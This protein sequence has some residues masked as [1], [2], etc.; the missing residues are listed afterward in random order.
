MALKISGSIFTVLLS[1]SMC[2]WSIVSCTSN[3]PETHTD[4]KSIEVPPLVNDQNPS[5]IFLPN[6]DSLSLPSGY[7]HIPSQGD[8][9]FTGAI[10]SDSEG[11]VMQYDIGG[12]SG[13]YV[14]LDHPD[15]LSESSVNENF[16]YTVELSGDSPV[17]S[18]TFTS[19]GPAN[20]YMYID[21][22]ADSR[23]RTMLQ[24]LKTYEAKEQD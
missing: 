6:G 7:M 14:Q 3:I 19:R 8:D 2:L 24:I 17:I 16:V 12:L 5:R 13:S 11:F 22:E 21:S 20:F 23:V 1:I 15:A 10:Q 4:S 9:S 18:A